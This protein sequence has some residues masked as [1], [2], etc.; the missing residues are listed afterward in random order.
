MSEQHEPGSGESRDGPLGGPHDRRLDSSGEDHPGVKPLPF[1]LIAVESTRTGLRLLGVGLGLLWIA[2]PMVMGTLVC[3]R[4]AV[5]LTG[6]TL[7]IVGFLC[8][9]LAVAISAPTPH[10]PLPKWA[11][12]V[13]ALVG[14]CATTSSIVHMVQWLRPEFSSA[15]SADVA[16]AIDATARVALLALPWILWRFCQYRGLSGRAIVW[17]WFAMAG[18]ALAIAVTYQDVG[19]LPFLFPPLGVI[20]FFAAQ[21]TAR[22][23]WLDAVY[24]NTKFHAT[25]RS[26]V[27]VEPLRPAGDR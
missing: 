22:D 21:Q 15:A 25:G 17:L 20:A 14:L 11:R 4:R 27:A 18:T 1:D 13:V 6:W 24:R 9:F 8:T 26:N 7:T 19:W 12:A 3:T 16:R 5:S 2:L 10:G 23:V